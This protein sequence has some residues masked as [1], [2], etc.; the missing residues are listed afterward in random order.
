MV[1]EIFKHASQSK[2]Q[3]IKALAENFDD[4]KIYDSEGVSLL[5]YAA[6]GLPD[7]KIAK[8]LIDKRVSCEGRQ[9]TPWLVY[10]Y[11]GFRQRKEDFYADYINQ[12]L[13]FHADEI[14]RRKQLGHRFSIIGTSSLSKFKF[15]YWGF[16]TDFTYPSISKSVQRFF[17]HQKTALSPKQRQ[18]IVHALGICNVTV[19]PEEL[20]RLYKEGKLVNIPTGWKNHAT[21]IVLKKG[22]FLIKGNKGYSRE[23][24]SLQVFEITKPERITKNLF[25]GLLCSYRK[26][27]SKKEEKYR[28]KYQTK[29][30]F[31]RKINER[32]GLIY[33]RKA[34]FSTKRQKGKN[35][36]WSS[37]AKLAFRANLFLIFHSQ[38]RSPKNAWKKTEKIFK[39]WKAWDLENQ[40][41]NYLKIHEKHNAPSPPD[42]ELLKKIHKKCLK[43]YSHL[44]K[45]IELSAP[46]TLK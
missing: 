45:K 34:S 6:A 20:Y 25:R 1:N 24:K 14:L 42:K 37:S 43:K 38:G 40:I 26:S 44:S 12:A 39:R 22:G 4:L 29:D 13:G 9:G 41:V 36:A 21:T 30:F 7:Y 11:Q 2:W 8:W 16:L 32:L 33:N 17:L 35:C 27:S 18:E 5:W 31:K 15:P 19:S 3:K 10:L 23:K 46:S 28:I